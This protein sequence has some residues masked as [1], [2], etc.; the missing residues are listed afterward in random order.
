MEGLIKMKSLD[1]A[2]KKDKNV[3][4]HARNAG[5]HIKNIIFKILLLFKAYIFILTHI[6]GLQ[7]SK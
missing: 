5:K 3:I 6:F 1:M 7:C 4:M 2:G